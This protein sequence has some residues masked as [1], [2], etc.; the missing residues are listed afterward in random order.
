MTGPFHVLDKELAII[1]CGD[2][3]DLHLGA[4]STGAQ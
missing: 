2:R 4:S 3:T 1:E